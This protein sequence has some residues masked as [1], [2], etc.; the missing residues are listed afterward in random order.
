M[1]ISTD[2]FRERIIAAKIYKIDKK[3]LKGFGILKY[4]S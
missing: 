2:F 4:A 3:V 1:F